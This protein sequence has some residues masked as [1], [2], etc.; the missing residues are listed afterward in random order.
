MDDLITI[1]QAANRPKE[2]LHLME[3]EALRR[4]TASD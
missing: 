2:R 3:F 4:L 1:K